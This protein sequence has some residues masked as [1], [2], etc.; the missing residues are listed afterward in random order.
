MKRWI[1]GALLASVLLTSTI[2]YAQGRLGGKRRFTPEQKASLKSAY[3]D[4]VKAVPSA[5]PAPPEMF[6]AGKRGGGG[7]AG[8]RRGVGR[9]GPLAQ[10]FEGLNDTCK[11]AVQ[12]A[13][14]KFLALRKEIWKAR[15]EAA[16][17]TK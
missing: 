17:A 9:G 1:T 14:E 16:A 13:Y 5:C 10:W 7:G 8:A 4:V 15:K 11:A 12:P 6:A 3:E 2:C